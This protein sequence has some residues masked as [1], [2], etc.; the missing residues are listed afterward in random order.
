[1]SREDGQLSQDPFEPVNNSPPAP[2]AATA[3]TPQASPLVAY[4]DLTP[5]EED[6][7]R[8]QQGGISSQ[9]AYGLT[10]Q[11]PSE[12]RGT[13]GPQNYL[14]GS[15]VGSSTPELGASPAVVATPARRNP[16]DIY[17][18]SRRRSSAS[19]PAAPR[20]FA[21]EGSAAPSPSVGGPLTPSRRPASPPAAEDTSP[22]QKARLDAPTGSATARRTAAAAAAQFEEGEEE[23]QPR[24]PSYAER[25]QAHIARYQQP[26]T[27][28][29]QAYTAYPTHTG[30][31]QEIA[32]R[33]ARLEPFP[34]GP[35]ARGG[36]SYAHNAQYS[37]YRA[38]RTG[39]QNSRDLIREHLQLTSNHPLCFKG[40]ATGSS[41]E[42]LYGD[43]TLEEA[44]AAWEEENDI[45]PDSGRRVSPWIEHLAQELGKDPLEA[46]PKELWQAVK[47]LIPRHSDAP[48]H[49]ESA[50]AAAAANAPE[51][52]SPPAP[53]AGD[54]AAAIVEASPGEH[55]QER[56]TAA[57]REIRRGAVAVKVEPASPPPAAALA[58]PAPQTAVP[59]TDG[60]ELEDLLGEEEI[61]ALTGVPRAAA[62]KPA[63]AR[64]YPY[65]D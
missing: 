38:P 11:T 52:S 42:D 5:T 43:K 26:P 59:P 61:S 34:G 56:H 40:S 17:V 49:G 46:A 20:P 31:E 64:T 39:T 29:R 53:A 12:Q 36:S 55:S 47:K 51:P 4:G 9:A 25:E 41:Y 28:P 10:A 1:M 48:E 8:Q 57:E 54:E 15:G 35:P 44:C 14:Y 45:E 18:R 24:R 21:L 30:V 50:R 23:D 60:G 13:P 58:A 63:D 22:S 7:Q 16:A 19:E 62:N 27:G 2:A 3:A 32:E 33:R 37:N 6:R 65:V